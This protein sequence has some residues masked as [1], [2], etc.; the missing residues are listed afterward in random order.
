MPIC[1]YLLHAD[2]GRGFSRYQRLMRR[3]FLAYRETLG[4]YYRRE[5]RWPESLF[6]RRR[7]L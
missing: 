6:W 5:Q 7:Q 2:G 1:D 3:E 4:D